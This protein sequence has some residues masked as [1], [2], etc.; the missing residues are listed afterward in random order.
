MVLNQNNSVLLQSRIKK[1]GNVL[2]STVQRQLKT[3]IE[4][5]GLECV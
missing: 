4:R 1:A 5:A 2:R 3:L